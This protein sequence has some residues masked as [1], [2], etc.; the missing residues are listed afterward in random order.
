MTQATK[1]KSAD[2]SG[3]NYKAP[4]GTIALLILYILLLVVLWG[5]AYLIMLS[6]GGTI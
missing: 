1:S 6:R 2:S 5:S 3:Q 4:A